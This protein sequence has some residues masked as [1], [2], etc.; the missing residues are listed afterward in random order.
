[1]VLTVAGYISPRD[2]ALCCWIV[3]LKRCKQPKNNDGLYL[4]TTADQS[5]VFTCGRHVSLFLS[6]HTHAH[7][8]TRT[9][10]YAFS[11]L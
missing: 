8:P 2:V 10:T 4:T 3:E 11:S 6:P 7:M 1:M 5:S 9:H